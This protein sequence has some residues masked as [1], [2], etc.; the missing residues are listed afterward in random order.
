MH[1]IR[2]EPC[3]SCGWTAQNGHRLLEPRSRGL[4]E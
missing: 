4:A 3:G 1:F 2:I